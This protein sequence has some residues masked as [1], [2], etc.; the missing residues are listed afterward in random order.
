MCKNMVEKGGL[1]SPLLVYNRTTARS[2]ALV[3]QLGGDGK[4]KVARTIAEA[5]TPANIVFICVGDDPA[6]EATIAEIL[7]SGDVSGKL[8]V[9]CS[10][11][12][13]DTTRKINETLRSKGASFVAMPVFGAPAFADLGQLICVPAGPKEDV[14][15]VLPYTIG[16]MARANIDFTDEEVGKAST[17]KL[18]GNSMVISLVEKLSESLTLAEKSG[19]GTEPLKQWLELM[20]PGVLPK[21]LT[22]METGD[23]Y[24]REYPLFA[25]DLA[26]KDVRHVMDIA[27]SSGMRMKSLEVAEGYLKHVKEHSGEKGDLAG[28]YGAVRKESGLKFEN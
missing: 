7:A 15:K 4:A 12:H 22:R 26:L 27:E 9:D 24:K 6:V 5:V 11:V 8:I 25:V 17:M 20:Y 1:A 23:Y 2:S 16:V 14:T 18:I 21:Y 19:V 10:T 13:P 28:M 3:E